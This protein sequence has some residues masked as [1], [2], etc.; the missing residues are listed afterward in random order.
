MVHRE[1]LRVSMHTVEKKRG[2]REENFRW[3]SR[4]SLR[5]ERSLNFWGRQMAV[6]N[7]L[8]ELSSSFSSFSLVNARK[9][10]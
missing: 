10:M 7:N 5:V 1:F 2:E 6:T 4:D 9:L 8:F 3:L